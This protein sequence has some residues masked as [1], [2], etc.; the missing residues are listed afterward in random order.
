M[1]H[2]LLY[3]TAAKWS[4]WVKEYQ[5]HLMKGKNSIKLFFLYKL[6]EELT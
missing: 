6:H 3:L 5:F 2:I 1:C 4:A